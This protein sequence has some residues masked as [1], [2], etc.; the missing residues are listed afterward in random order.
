MRRLWIQ[1]IA[2]LFVVAGSLGVATGRGFD[3]TKSSS[4]SS[5]KGSSKSGAKP[6]SP[7][8]GDDGPPSELNTPPPSPTEASPPVEDPLPPP[9]IDARLPSFDR[10]NTD[11]KT[12]DES[13]SGN[14]KTESTGQDSP[15]FD[16]KIRRAQ[17]PAN[18]TNPLP[19][20]IDRPTSSA[21]SSGAGVGAVS[22]DPGDAFVIPLNRIPEGRQDLGVSVEV[23]APSVV[24]LFQNSTLKV[25]VKNKGASDAL[26]V[27]VRDDLPEGLSFVES[28]PATSP[29][30]QLLVWRIG[31]LAAGSEKVILLKVKPTQVG[32]FDH[33][34]SVSFM[35]GG[36]SRTLVQEP[37][38]V[39][40]QSV[41]PSKVL[42]GQQVVYNIAVS[43]PGT[44][45]ARNVTVIAR[46]SP[47]LRHEQGDELKQVI[48][49][50]KPGERVKLDPLYTDA[51]ADGEQFCETT[52]TSPDV[53]QASGPAKRTD[54]VTVVAPKLAVA[55]D[56]PKTRYTDTPAI[57]HVTISNPG[58]APAQNI[59]VT[60]MLP[61]TGTVT[62][63]NGAQ[64]DR[65]GS[66]L[67]WTLDQLEAGQKV[68]YSFQV[69]LGGVQ[70]YQVAIQ[71]KADHGLLEKRTFETDVTGIADVDFFVNER[72]RVVDVGETVTYE[73]VIKNTGSREAA[74]LLVSARL[75]KNLEAPETTGTEQSAQFNASANVVKF[76]VIARLAPRD[77]EIVLSIKAKASEPGV[78]TC[79][80]VLLHDDLGDTQLVKTAATKVMPKPLGGKP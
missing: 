24:N 77:G 29:A 12:S 75:S 64:H 18:E 13:A 73:I 32:S 51:V 25:I 14:S 11:D 74:N 6:A 35:T 40:E 69:R 48:P 26:G 61:S 80:V 79:E 66:R 71:A 3:D 21:G 78:A 8:A 62:H 55:I 43:N 33:A 42:K 20:A 65:F 36:R 5:T 28:Q 17:G 46:L 1:T 76:P 57:Y 49:L 22:A 41:S 34:A 70:L 50:I 44:G 60:A 9:E 31:T 63:A 27:I 72:L 59:R 37:K 68:D 67:L 39:I 19:N 2:I 56:G 45:P 15:L 58:T 53:L 54:A 10:P 38:L 47:G 23:V 30:G 52:A 4:K 7:E 16:S